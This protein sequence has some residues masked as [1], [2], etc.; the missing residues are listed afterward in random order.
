M[1]RGE[2]G[3]QNEDAEDTAHMERE[4]FQQKEKKEETARIEREKQ[5]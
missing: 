5:E 1:G 3:Q 2:D 4:K